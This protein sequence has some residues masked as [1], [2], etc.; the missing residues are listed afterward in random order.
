MRI[1]FI[2][3]S[4]VIIAIV[5]CD[6]LLGTAMESLYFK[7]KQGKMYNVTYALE[8][9][10]TDILIL[11]S[12]RAMHHYN[13]DVIKKSLGLTCYNAGFDGR[14]V[15]YHNALIG[16]ISKRYTPKVIIVD[17]NRYEF[18]S[19]VKSYALLNILAP[20]A[21]KH[22][23]LEK[24]LKL[25]SDYEHIKHISRIY[26]YNS[27][28]ARMVMGCL[29]FKTK[30]VSDNGFT[31]RYGIWSGALKTVTPQKSL[32]DE[33]KIKSFKAIIDLCNKNRIKLFFVV[34]PSFLISTFESSTFKYIS[35]YCSAHD[36][37]FTDYTNDEHYRD[38]NLF[39]DPGHLNRTGADIFSA[40]LC[41]HLKKHIIY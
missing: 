36:I 26:P 17:V 19:S 32:F 18:D 27:L 4:L 22:K 8:E 37:L 12:S 9:C 30:D 21:N 5:I 33:N 2:K 39:L 40:D 24:T 16:V 29:S 7:Q 23:E 10:E 20:Y 38:N 28:F 6:Y 15:I 34:S 25:R 14:G 35:D 31:P 41:S 13:P 11:G 3:L 1:F